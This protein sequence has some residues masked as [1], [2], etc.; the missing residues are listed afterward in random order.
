MPATSRVDRRQHDEQ[1]RELTYGGG[2]NERAEQQQRD[3]LRRRQLP[4]HVIESEIAVFN[5]PNGRFV[6][7]N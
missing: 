2:G 4:E 7:G 5:K 3:A 1:A 6:N